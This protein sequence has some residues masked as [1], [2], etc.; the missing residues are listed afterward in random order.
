MRRILSAGVLSA[1]LLPRIAAAHEQRV[2]QNVVDL[3]YEIAQKVAR[4]PDFLNAPTPL[5]TDANADDWRR[6]RASVVTS[7]P[8]LRALPAGFPALSKP[9]SVSRGE[10]AT[11]LPRG[12]NQWPTL[13]EVSEPIG[14]VYP[15]G[16]DCSVLPSWSPWGIYREGIPAG[17]SPDY[18]GLTLGAFA[19]H[20]DNQF[21]DSHVYR[22][23]P[24][25]ALFPGIQV[26]IEVTHSLFEKGLAV[27]LAPFACLHSL[28]TGGPN[29]LEHARDLASDL[30]PIDD[31]YGA[32]PGAFDSS[33]PMTVGF[34]HFISVAPGRSNDFDDVGGLLID[35]GYWNGDLDLAELVIIAQADLPGQFLN[36]DDSEGPRRYE[37]L[38]GRD[39]HPNTEKRSRSEW[40]FHS[41]VHTQ[42]APLDNLAKW[43][44]DRFLEKKHAYYLGWP[45]HALGDAVQPHH[46]ISAPG[47]GH[48]PLEH[49]VDC[50]WEDIIYKTEGTSV[51]FER[52]RLEEQRRQAAR[53]FGRALHFRRLI[54]DWRAK[55]PDSRA[56]LIP[57]RDL[58]TALARET[59]D[60]A[61][62]T[63]TSHQWP[64]DAEA[65][66]K[67]FLNNDDLGAL[68]RPDT[69]DLARPLLE[70]GA[71]AILAFLSFA[72]EMP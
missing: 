48:A 54:L 50:A 2:H 17:S 56:R 47:W 25:N 49:A 64:F 63:M 12:W 72:S 13:G 36:Y 24:A 28:L 16:G 21:D 45:L 66:A 26:P 51:L 5:P 9:C 18:T 44:W 6:F 40:Q 3:A 33:G 65:S 23:R 69:A 11:N 22:L 20:V 71:G 52:Q 1:L 8:R 19:A 37:I 31:F 41:Y 53:I 43:G 57:V 32:L 15:L 38:D 62:G 58:V 7:V 61:I 4:D 67:N 29:C 39:G 14:W 59:H 42:M 27:V 46:T 55:D 35:E 10:T 30:N 68:D 34:W 70:N 60:Y